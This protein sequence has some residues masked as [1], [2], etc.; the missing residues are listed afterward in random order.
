VSEAVQCQQCG[1]A[2]QKA[3]KADKVDP[4]GWL[5]GFIGLCALFAYPVG[6]IFGVILILVAMVYSQKKVWQ[7]SKCGYFFER[8]E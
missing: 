6:T 5:I 1:G 3:Q 7:C 4:G 8:A 2:M